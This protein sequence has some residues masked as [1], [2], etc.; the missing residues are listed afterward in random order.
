MRYITA[1]PRFCYVVAMYSIFYF[2][3]NVIDIRQKYFDDKD[4]SID[5]EVDFDSKIVFLPIISY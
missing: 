4:K 3:Q 2:G 1:K 5:V